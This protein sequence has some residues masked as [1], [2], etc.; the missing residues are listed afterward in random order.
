MRYLLNRTVMRFD[1][2]MAVV[3]TPFAASIRNLAAFRANV[4]NFNGKY[5]KQSIIVLPYL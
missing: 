5:V 3:S 1:Y 2:M 4:E